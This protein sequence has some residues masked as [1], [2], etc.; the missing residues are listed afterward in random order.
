MKGRCDDAAGEFEDD[1]K[2]TSI[3][4]LLIQLG[5]LEPGRG[6]ERPEELEVVLLGEPEDPARRALGRPHRARLGRR[7]SCERRRPPSRTTSSL[8]LQSF[9]ARCSGPGHASMLTAGLL[10]HDAELPAPERRGAR[11][12]GRGTPGAA[13]PRGRA[14]G[15]RVAPGRAERSRVAAHA[16]LDG[17]NAE[18][19]PGSATSTLRNIRARS[20]RDSATL[21]SLSPGEPQREVR[22]SLPMR[23]HSRGVAE[24]RPRTF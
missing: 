1:A 23:S 6:K 8:L 7:G 16:R 14:S 22:K 2:A 10:G 9:V 12:H 15:P 24:T 4:D 13:E 11:E 21:G 18:G 20:R 17:A 19:R 5:G 3:D